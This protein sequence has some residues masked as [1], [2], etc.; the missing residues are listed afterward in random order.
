M[1]PKSMDEYIQDMTEEEINAF[2]K[3]IK[4]I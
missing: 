4:W 2:I 1:K 3:S